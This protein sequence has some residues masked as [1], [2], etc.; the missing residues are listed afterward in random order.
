MC[1]R[2]L[3]TIGSKDKTVIDKISR[4]EVKAYLFIACC[5]RQRVIMFLSVSMFICSISKMAH[6]QI[7]MKLSDISN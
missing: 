4:I 7:L 1:A 5:Q 2:I 6:E 3:L